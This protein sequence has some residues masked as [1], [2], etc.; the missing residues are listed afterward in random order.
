[1]DSDLIES[2]D[3]RLVEM[4]LNGM[5]EELDEIIEEAVNEAVENL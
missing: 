3:N 1:M 5:Y 4:D 2:H